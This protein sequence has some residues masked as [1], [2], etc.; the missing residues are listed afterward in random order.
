MRFTPAYAASASFADQE[1]ARR[2]DGYFNRSFVDP[3]YGRP[4]PADMVAE[5]T[6]QG[7]LPNGRSLLQPGKMAAF[8]APTD[9]LVGN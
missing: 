3:V 4:Y 8:P 2:F 7:H 6:A 1:A 5:S 9:C